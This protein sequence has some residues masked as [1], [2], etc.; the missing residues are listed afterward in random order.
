MMRFA[1]LLVVL[2]ASRVWAQPASLTETPN[3]VPMAPNAI[4][5]PDC[6][7]VS[8]TLTAAGTATVSLIG[9]AARPDAAPSAIVVAGPTRT[10]NTIAVQVSPDQGC[11]T[12]GCRNGNSYLI[13]LRPEAGTDRPI[14]VI[15]VNVRK[16]VS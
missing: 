14:C 11:G 3:V 1:A 15:R 12:A 5:T 6:E 13:T 4:L 8:W 10:G 16:V 2:C 9:P 7:F